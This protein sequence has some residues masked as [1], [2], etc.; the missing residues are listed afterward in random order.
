[1]SE[2][3][4]MGISRTARIFL[5]ALYFFIF[6]FV[7]Y[8]PKRPRNT[9]PKQPGQINAKQIR[10][11]HCINQIHPVCYPGLTFLR[12]DTQLDQSEPPLLE[13]HLLEGYCSL[14]KISIGNYRALDLVALQCL[15]F[16]VSGSTFPIFAYKI[17]HGKCVRAI[18]TSELLSYQK[19]HSFDF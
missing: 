11:G 6:V 4:N 9:V 10:P 3:F 7:F 16:A 8:D 15:V 19:S 5:F 18:F 17:L 14:E 13:I 2:N 1:M 12:T